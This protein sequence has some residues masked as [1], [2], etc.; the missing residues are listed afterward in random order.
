MVLV[1]HHKK[2]IYYDN[3]N[4][5]IQSGCVSITLLMAKKEITRWYYGKFRHIIMH[6]KEW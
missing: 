6:C 2:N 1:Q 5:V 3:S 4:K